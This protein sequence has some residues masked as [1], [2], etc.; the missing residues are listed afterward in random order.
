MG[1]DSERLVVVEMS[2]VVEYKIIGKTQ[3][4]CEKDRNTRF[5]SFTI[6]ARVIYYG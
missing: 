2:L 5:F 6:T 3:R 4:E 1:T